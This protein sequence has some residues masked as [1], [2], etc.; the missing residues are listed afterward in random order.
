MSGHDRC[1]GHSGGFSRYRQDGAHL[2]GE[3]ACR[4]VGMPGGRFRAYT[5]H[6]WYITA[7]NA[8]IR[9]ERTI[10]GE[11]PVLLSG[12]AGDLHPPLKLLCMASEIQIPKLAKLRSALPVECYGVFS[13][14]NY[15]EI[16]KTGINKGSALRQVWRYLQLQPE[17]VMAVG[18]GASRWVRRHCASDVR[19]TIPPRAMM[20]LGWPMPFSRS[21]FRIE[22]HRCRCPDPFHPAKTPCR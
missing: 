12:W 17:D 15:L 18:D 7:W 21:Y 1:A 3:A 2:E 13:H 14:R 11:T 8:A 5:R 20:R 10:T 16:M 22:G 9:R 6:H 19:L 4:Y